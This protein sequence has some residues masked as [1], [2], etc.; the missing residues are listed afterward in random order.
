VPS[1]SP[2]SGCSLFFPTSLIG[3]ENIGYHDP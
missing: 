2:Q 3:I 1:S